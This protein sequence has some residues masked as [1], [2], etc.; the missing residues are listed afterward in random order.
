MINRVRNA[1]EKWKVGVGR[2]LNRVG[3]GKR[4]EG[5]L[6]TPGNIVG[7]TLGPRQAYAWQRGWGQQGARVPRTEWR[8]KRPQLPLVAFG[9]FL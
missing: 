3:L 5:A 7:S 6:Q 2:R 1:G 4:G 8:S 9:V